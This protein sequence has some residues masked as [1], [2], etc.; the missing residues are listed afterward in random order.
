MTAPVSRPA[1]PPGTLLGTLGAA[2]RAA[3]LALGTRRT[4]QP[5]TALVNEGSADAGTFALLHGYAK[6]F[7][8]TADGRAVLLSIRAGGDLVGELA[9]LD[10]KPRSASVVAATRVVAQAVSQQAFLRYLEERPS[11]AKAIHGAVV[12]EYRRVT[13]ERV[14]MNGAPTAVRLAL[15]LNHLTASYGRPCADGVRIEVPLSQPEL[16]SLVGVSEPTLHRCLTDLRARDIV[17]TRYRHLIVTDPGALQALDH[18]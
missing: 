1:W 2:D 17:R 12:A 14:H 7:G 10:D 8:T 3:L 9:A 6:V 15:V 16:A 4:Y 11:A 5:G 13:S 18:A